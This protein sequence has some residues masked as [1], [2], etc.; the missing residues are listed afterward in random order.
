MLI[1][2]GS[3]T[4][5]SNLNGLWPNVSSGATASFVL[6]L[7]FVVFSA[8]ELQSPRKKVNKQLLR[9]SYTANLSLFIF[10]SLVMSLLSASMLWVVAK[11]HFT[12]GFLHAITNPALNVT[13]SLLAL[14]L[15][16]YCWH[17]AC[18]CYDGLW[19]FHK[20]HHND[21]YLNVST[22]FRIHISESFM[23]YILKLMAIILLGIDEGIVLVNEIVTTL[24]VLFHHTNST[25]KGE[26]WFGYVFTTPTLH[27][28]HHSIERKEHDNNYGAILT[29]W[30]R[31]LGTFLERE[32]TEIGIKGYSPLDF[33]NLVK[34]GFVQKLLPVSMPFSLD[35][36]I[37]EAA[38]YKAEKR[39]FIPGYEWDDWLEAKCDI[40]NMVSK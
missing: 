10:N 39:N 7:S 27:R 13:L 5:L 12:Q 14:D 20:V 34:F 18:H 29:I 30:D 16:L 17:R 21:P 31:L 24:F 1:D 32:P 25:F 28:T 35:H 36:M 11:Q 40:L 33:F 2:L 4:S 15:L 8:I 23:T 19:M 3:L 37:A 38:Y 6:I 26:K 22:G 9:Q